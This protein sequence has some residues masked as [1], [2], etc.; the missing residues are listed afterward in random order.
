MWPFESITVELRF[1]LTPCVTVP[2]VLPLASVSEIEAGG[3][4]EKYPAD[5][6]VDEREAVI[7]AV[8]G[9]SA[10]IWFVVALMDPIAELLPPLLILKF[11][12]PMEDSQVG[13]GVVVVT[14]AADPEHVAVPLERVAVVGGAVAFMPPDST[15]SGVPPVIVLVPL[16][17]NV[18]VAPCEPLLKFVTLQYCPAVPTTGLTEITPEHVAVPLDSVAWVGE[19][20]APVPPAVIKSGVPLATVLDEDRVMV[21]VVPV[22]PLL[23]LLTLQV[24]PA[25]PEIVPPET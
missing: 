10:V 20:V 7:S 12:V 23:K 14:T 13:T 11:N 4:T 2:A 16:N 21:A 18:A 22:P 6:P 25:D 24:C 1:W 5:D 17:V 8:P 9:C 15:I 3:H 19:A